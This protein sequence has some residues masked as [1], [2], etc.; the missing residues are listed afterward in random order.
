M[1]HKSSLGGNA[2]AYTARK[3]RAPKGATSGIF[4]SRVRGVKA[5]KPPKVAKVPKGGIFA[6]KSKVGTP[7]TKVTA[8]TNS[9]GSFGDDKSAM[10]NRMKTQAGSRVKG[11]G[12][13]SDQAAALAKA[14]NDAMQNFKNRR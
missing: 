7:N 4:G 2:P 13:S 8:P 9:F 6:P 3:K 14:K 5:P 10:L 11:S 1:P 12:A